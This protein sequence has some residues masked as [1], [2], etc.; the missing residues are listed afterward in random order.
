MI[1]E[2]EFD[3]AREILQPAAQYLQILTEVYAERTAIKA[4][5]SVQPLR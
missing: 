3:V 4:V 5:T 1:I 2:L